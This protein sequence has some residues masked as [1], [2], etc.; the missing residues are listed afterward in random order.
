MQ[1]LGDAIKLHIRCLLYIQISFLFCWIICW[2]KSSFHSFYNW[3]TLIEAFV[4]ASLSFYCFALNYL[5]QASIYFV[6]RANAIL[7]LLF[8]LHQSIF[9]DDIWLICPFWN[10]DFLLRLQIVLYNIKDSYSRSCLVF[11]LDE[12]YFAA[13][14]MI[15]RM[16]AFRKFI[17]FKAVQENLKSFITFTSTLHRI[18]MKNF[19]FPF[20][21]LW[22][23]W[24]SSSLLQ[25][26]S[27]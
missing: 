4:Q 6:S 15:Y 7:F 23:F 2:G 1:L 16:N 26:F 25:G 27:L 20:P 3:K 21:D 14:I 9:V 19:R 24:K 12:F 5:M 8:Y 22:K 18:L 11:H 17:V 10:R 13:S